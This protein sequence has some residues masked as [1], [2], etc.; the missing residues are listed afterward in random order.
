MPERGAGVDNNEVIIDGVKLDSNFPLE[1][2]AAACESLGIS[3]HGGKAKRLKRPCDHFQAEELIAAHGA[4]HQL[5]GDLAGPVHSQF[6]PAEP[7]EK[8][9]ADHNLVHQHNVLSTINMLIYIAPEG[10]K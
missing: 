10:K 7:I 9:I 5:R 8:R 1:T 3:G 2:L 6:A 4:Q